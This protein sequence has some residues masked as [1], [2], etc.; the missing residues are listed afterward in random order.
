[1]K[2]II[3]SKNPTKIGAV[4]SVFNKADVSGLSVP[5]DVSAQPLSDEETMQGAINRAKHCLEA[6][7]DYGIGLEGGVMEIGETMYLCNWGA[8]A[9]A[10]GTVLTAS[11]ARISLPED[12]KSALK[13]GEELG[14]VMDRFANK[15]DVRSNEG[16][17]GIFTENRMS[18]KA[19]FEHV[20]QLLCG[21]LEY[22]SRDK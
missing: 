18:R 17:I 14:D 10:D 19:M 13:S 11:G 6:G 2:V 5:S 8:L 3:G 22:K 20:V 1:M 16:S 15:K 9:L 4:A 7:A 12:I 21:Q